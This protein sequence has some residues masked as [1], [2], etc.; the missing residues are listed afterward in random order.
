MK[1][2][3]FGLFFTMMSTLAAASPYQYVLKVT[4]LWTDYYGNKGII[5]ETSNPCATDMNTLAHATK[6]VVVVPPNPAGDRMFMVGSMAYS[7]EE[8]IFVHCSDPTNKY[9]L[10]LYLF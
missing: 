2:F 7:L 10:D 5:V 6:H 1:K 3:L 4:G 8:E 9:V